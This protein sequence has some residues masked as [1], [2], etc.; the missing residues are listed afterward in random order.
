MKTYAAYCNDGVR[1]V[2]SSGGVFSL[3]ASKYDV[4]YG[5]AITQ[6]CHGAEFRRI[7]GDISSLRG[8]KYLQAKVGD[9]FRQAKT[10]LDLGKLVLF[11]GTGCQINGLKTFLQR[12]YE[13]LLA[14]DVV[15]HGVPSPKLWATYAS[16]KEHEMGR[17]LE[18]VNFRCKERKSEHFHIQEN[19]IYISKDNDPYMQ[20]FLRDYAL[21]PSC[22]HCHAKTLK[23]SDMTIADFWGIE[24]V[25]PEMNDGM[26]TSLVIIRTKKGHSVFELLKPNLSWKEV[27]YEDGVHNNPSEYQSP[28]KPKQRDMFYQDLINLSFPEMEE[29]Y[30]SPPKI[31]III[32]IKR[33]IIHLIKKFYHG[34]RSVSD[35]QIRLNSE[36]GLLLTFEE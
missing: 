12:D 32:R 17:K 8:S 13:N 1:K 20:M 19:Q 30:L 31:S 28:E 35:N 2:S 25:A 34:R 21:R 7:T 33:I 5:V 24:S 15:C 16:F 26:G 3:L 23:M 10:D 6:D 22:Y 11:T 27:T 36:Y 9:A 18:S 14:V 4:V 29:K